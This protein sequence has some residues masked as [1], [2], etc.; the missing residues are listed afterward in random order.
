MIRKANINDPPQILALVNHFAERGLMLPR[1]LNELYDH[2][3]DFFVCEKDG[4]IVACAAL[5]VSWESLG[6]VRSL[7][8][9]EEAQRRGIGT[10]MVQACLKEARE[11]GMK[12]VF[13]LT[14]APGFFRRFGFRD[15]PKEKL[16]HK[17]WADC[18]KCPKFPNCDEEALLVD[19][20]GT[21]ETG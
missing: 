9:I 10:Q 1:A 20:T 11:L 15:Y 16:P 5:H 6:E 17:I 13:A 4:R 21:H 8:V 7:A 19:L 3:R 14:Y 12:R 18:L 2:L